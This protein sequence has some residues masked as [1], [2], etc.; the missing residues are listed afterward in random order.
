VQHW[1]V[2]LLRCSDGSLYTGVTTDLA[3]RL[4]EHNAGK[5][6]AYT[7]AKRPVRLVFEEAHPSR[8][9]ALKREAEI[10]SWD[11]TKKEQLR[12]RPAMIKL[13]RVYE[14]PRQ[15]EG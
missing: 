13:K 4:A 14:A 5:G 12:E 7:R 3:R 9:S 15:A 10:K 11:R 8:S 2:Y 1:L 6:G